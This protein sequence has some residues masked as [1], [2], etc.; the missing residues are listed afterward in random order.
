M[1]SCA[2]VCIYIYSIIIMVNAN[3]LDICKISGISTSTLIS[4]CNIRGLH[5]GVLGIKIEL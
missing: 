1:M 2:C 4:P 3:I 5:R